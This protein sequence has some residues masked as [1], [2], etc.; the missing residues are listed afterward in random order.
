M[1][2]FMMNKLPQKEVVKPYEFR[3]FEIASSEKVTLYKNALEKV[4]NHWPYHRHELLNVRLNEEAKLMCFLYSKEDKVQ[5]VMPFYMRPIAIGNQKT[6]YFDVTSPWGY[7]GPLFRGAVQEDIAKEFWSYVDN[8]YAE[9]NVV[10]EFVRFNFLDSHLFYSGHSVHTLYNVR[11]ELKEDDVI[12]NNIQSKT[13]NKIRNAYKNNLEFVMYHGDIPEDKVREFYE[14]Y[15]STMDRNQAVD[16]FYHTLDYFREFVAANLDC[17]AI[18]MVYRD[19]KAVS[20]ELF[21][22][23]NDTIFSFLGGTFSD[24]FKYRPNDFLKMETIKWAREKGLKFYV[25]GGGLKDNDSLYQYKKKFFRFDDDLQFFTGR[26]ILNIEAYRE[27]VS[28]ALPDYPVEELTAD[29]VSE[30]YFPKY[31]RP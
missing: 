19:G 7:T 24:Y 16:T 14:I 27:L 12:W 2:D 10:T 20:T 8:W 22:M 9:N 25:I 1:S 13:K 5:V 31:R 11:G 28:M 6:G 4:G 23:T 18:G 17:C 29:S 26:K 15:I 30:G 21:L 3:V